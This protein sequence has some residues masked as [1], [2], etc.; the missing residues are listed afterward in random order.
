MIVIPI[1]KII[2]RHF[3]LD[4]LKKIIFALAFGVAFQGRKRI[5]CPMV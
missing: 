5:D 2:P 1:N 3:C 4:V